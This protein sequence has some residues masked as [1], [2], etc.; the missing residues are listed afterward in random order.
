VCIVLS[1]TAA[2]PTTEYAFE[3]ATSTIRFGSGVTAEVGYDFASMGARN[4][5]LVTDA[6]LKTLPPVIAAEQSLKV[7][8]SRVQRRCAA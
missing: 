7:G 5:L 4:V 6:T 8:G 3:M 1:G 2:K